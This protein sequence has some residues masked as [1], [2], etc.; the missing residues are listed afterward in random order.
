MICKKKLFFILLVC[1]FFIYSE[2]LVFP[3]YL[4]SYGIRKATPKHLFMFFGA[5]TFFSDPQGLATVKMDSWDNPASKKDDDEVIVYGINSG[6]HE[7][8]YNK[9]MYSLAIFGCKGSG[10]NCFLFPKGIAI[11]SKGDVYVA[12]SGNNRIVHLYNPKSDLQ[13]IGSFNGVTLTDPGI[14]GPR[15]VALDENGNIYVTDAVHNK[16]FIFSK[17]KSVRRYIPA[18]KNDLFIGSPTA[19][20]VADGS[21][22]WSYFKNE[23]VLFCADKNGSRLWKIDLN[24]SVLKCI[25]LPEGHHAFYGAIDYYHNYWITDISKH[26]LLKFD[27]DLKLLDIFGSF[28]TKK[29]QFV[30]PRGI[31]IHK[32]FG[33]VFIAEKKGAQYYWIGTEL[34]KAALRRDTGE[35]YCLT[36]NSTEYSFVSLFTLNGKDTTFFCKRRMFFPGSDMKMISDIDI[37]INNHP[38]VLKIEPTYSSFTYNSWSYPITISN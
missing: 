11:N 15:R 13:W 5:S 17:E 26:C 4:H 30:E 36:V 14:F 21:A 18:N 25:D 27:H 10:K 22:Q 16:I 7:L 6:H 8:I 3:P 23:R 2:S 35:K 1:S 33:Q 31:A 38:L 12:D 34:K 20:A 29:D 9:S 19:L 32:R 28:G 37:N 24:G